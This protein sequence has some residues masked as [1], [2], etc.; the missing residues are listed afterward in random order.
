MPVCGSRIR[1]FI[2]SR[3]TTRAACT[4]PPCGRSASAYGRSTSRMPDDSADRDLPLREDTRLLG[5]YLGD[6]VRTC[7][8]DDAYERVEAIRQAAI[9]F[10]RAQPADASTLRD[11]LAAHLNHLTIAQ[12]LNVVR[13]F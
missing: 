11:E 7:T 10:R 1:I 3:A 8:G 9:R 4:P 5:R 13:A 2:R 6:V 12:T